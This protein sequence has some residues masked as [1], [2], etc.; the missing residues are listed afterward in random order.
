[1]NLKNNLIHYAYHG[2]DEQIFRKTILE[3][4]SYLS[5][6]VYTTYNEETLNNKNLQFL[7]AVSNKNYLNIVELIKE[8]YHIISN[9]E[10]NS[11]K[12]VFFKNNSG[13]QGLI[14]IPQRTTIQ[15]KSSILNRDIYTFTLAELNRIKEQYNLTFLNN[16]DKFPLDIYCGALINCLAYHLDITIEYFLI[17]LY[18]NSLSEYIKYFNIYKKGKI[19]S[20]TRIKNETYRHTKLFSFYYYWVFK[21]IKETLPLKNKSYSFHDIGTQMAILPAMIL[22]QNKKELM[23]VNINKIIASDYIDL[24][25]EVSAWIES[26]IDTAKGIMFNFEK[27]NLLD[28]P[29][30]FPE[31]DITVVINVLEYLPDDETA[32]KALLKIWEH[33]K[34]IL[35]IHVPIET[36][37]TKWHDHNILF[38]PDKIRKWA[39]YLKNGKFL[40]DSFKDG[41]N[42]LLTDNGFL[43]V[44][45]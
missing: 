23:N 9:F 15:L 34:K 37:E 3:Q 7:T 35:I 42:N 22:K 19:A 2:M 29:G 14:F 17:K 36:E 28:L 40:S 24:S 32:L 39:S 20:D 43:I 33:T 45:K 27:I 8:N 38:N 30:D 41:I 12:G 25:A 26:Y 11:I 4:L 1:M 44:I 5:D 13:L 31:S 16:F 18:E 21:I 6:Y 10:N